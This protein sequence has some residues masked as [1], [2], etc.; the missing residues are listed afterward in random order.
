[1]QLEMQDSRIAGSTSERARR[2]SC[3]SLRVK[4]PKAYSALTQDQ[5]D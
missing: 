1:M 4:R 2:G 5:I 3:S